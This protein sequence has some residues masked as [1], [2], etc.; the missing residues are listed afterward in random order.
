MK[1]SATVLTHPVFARPTVDQARP[2]GRRPKSII[3]FQTAGIAIKLAREKSLCAPAPANSART[4]CAQ[5][6]QFEMLFKTADAKSAQRLQDFLQ[7]VI[8]TEVNRR[9]R[10]GASK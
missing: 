2:H 9:I 8:D 7:A 3:N 4:A 5:L 10:E 1:I 6:Q